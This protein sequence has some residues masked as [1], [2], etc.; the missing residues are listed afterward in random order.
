MKN[1]FLLSISLYQ[2]VFS[3]IIK[4]ILG[5]SGSCR[6]SPTCSQYARIVIARQGPIKGSLLTLARVVSCQPVNLKQHKEKIKKY[7]RRIGLI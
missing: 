7:A 1:I 5:I 4:N 2:K 6:Y 3:V